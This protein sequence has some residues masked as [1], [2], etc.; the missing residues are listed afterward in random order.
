MLQSLTD[1][2]LQ[3]RAKEL[4]LS[5]L[6]PRSSLI[7]SIEALGSNLNGLK[8]VE[9]KR[10]TKP[11]RRKRKVTRQETSSDAQKNEEEEDSL[12]VEIEY[13]PESLELD[14]E[15]AQFANVFA[16][17]QP[18][19]VPL[20]ESEL[21]SAFPAPLDQDEMDLASDDSEMDEPLETEEKKL[22]KKKLRKMMRPSV[23]ELKRLVKKPEVVDVCPLSENRVLHYSGS[24]SRLQILN[25]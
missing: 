18:K 15:F 22:S 1:I 24:M 11:R 3:T 5:V 6:G 25:Y 8:A 10:K 21:N 23:A 7:A 20:E 4:G 19:E 14:P 2:E 12:Q 9:V 17:F 13:V 16:K